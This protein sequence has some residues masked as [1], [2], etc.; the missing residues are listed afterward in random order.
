MLQLL[1]AAA[2][3]VAELPWNQCL[4]HYWKLQLNKDKNST[5]DQTL[6]NHILC[7]VAPACQHYS[8]ELGKN[9]CHVILRTATSARQHASTTLQNCSSV[10]KNCWDVITADCCFWWWITVNLLSMNWVL[11]SESWELRHWWRLEKAGARG[12]DTSSKLSRFRDG[13]YLL[14]CLGSSPFI[15]CNPIYIPLNNDNFWSQ[16]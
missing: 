6:Q 1:P 14:K 13:I 7:T 12:Y 10:G 3:S 16:Y 5:G 4:L 9:C 15:W 8:A 2:K 11:E